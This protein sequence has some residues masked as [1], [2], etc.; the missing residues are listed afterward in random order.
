MRKMSSHIEPMSALEEKLV[1]AAFCG[2]WV[3]IH[4]L[5][6]SLRVSQQADVTVRGAFLRK[7]LLGLI[8]PRATAGHNPRTHGIRLRGAIISGEI[9]LSDCVGTKGSP[10]PPLLLE[11]CII[12]GAEFVKWSIGDTSVVQKIRRAIN[13]ANARLSRFSL[14]GCRVD[15]RVDLTGAKLEGPLEIS[16]IAPLNPNCPCQIFA[17]RCRISGSLIATNAK[18]QIRAGLRTEFDES[19][20]SLNLVNATIDGSVIL[21]PC[22]VAI[23]GVDVRNARV[24]RDIWAE[25]AILKASGF[26]EEWG[27]EVDCEFRIPTVTG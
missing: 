16:N 24:S 2:E 21:Q 6:T 5:P 26:Q 23:G 13:A 27:S 3:G 25:A 14:H 18:L 20:Y 4:E 10:L 8:P 9:D 7:L 15:G 17:R 11:H 12:A 22:F 19:D 1:D